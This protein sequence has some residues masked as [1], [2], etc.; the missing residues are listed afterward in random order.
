MQ[1][2]IAWSKVVAR[3]TKVQP[4][5]VVTDHYRWGFQLLFNCMFASLAQV[6]TRLLAIL[7]VDSRWPAFV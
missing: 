4:P 1:I 7:L 6:G 2:N 3:N 5:V